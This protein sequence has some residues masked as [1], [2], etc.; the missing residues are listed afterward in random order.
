MSDEKILWDAIAKFSPRVTSVDDVEAKIRTQLEANPGLGSLLAQ[1]IR[2][3]KE[4]NKLIGKCLYEMCT[5]RFRGASE[6]EAICGDKA[7]SVD[8]CRI[9]DRYE[10]LEYVVQTLFKDRKTKKSLY[11]LHQKNR[12]LVEDLTRRRIVTLETLQ[13]VIERD[14]MAKHGVDGPTKAEEV[15]ALVAKAFE[16]QEYDSKYHAELLKFQ[17][18]GFDRL[19]ELKVPFFCTSPDCE[20]AALDENRKFLTQMMGGIMDGIKY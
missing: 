17:K 2:R 12:A 16:D 13:N 5:G 9:T 1:T 6:L 19:R 10:A 18:D 20:T 7:Q 11:A 14:W 4:C 3:E 15:S 8:P